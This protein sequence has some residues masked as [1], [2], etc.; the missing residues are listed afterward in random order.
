MSST[1]RKKLI[2]ALPLLK[3]TAESC[4]ENNPFLP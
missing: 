1:Q 3:P 4:K 2:G